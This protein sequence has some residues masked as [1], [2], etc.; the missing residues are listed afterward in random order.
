M[1]VSHGF[2]HWVEKN[3]DDHPDV[4]AQA[5]GSHTHRYVNGRLHQKVNLCLSNPKVDEFIIAEWKEAGT[6]DFWNI[7]NNDLGGRYCLCDDCR[8]MDIPPGQSLEDL[9]AGTCN[10][11]GRHV[12]F[13]RRLL[14]QMREINPDITLGAYAFQQYRFAPPPGTG[15]EGMM[16]SV[17]S[18][19]DEFE[20]WVAWYETGARLYLR[21]NWWHHT[22][23]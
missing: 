2:Q 11:T 14:D 23:R 21:P 12:K 16:I 1:R 6:P 8:A 13:W 15:L 5:R 19:H 17:V 7:G 22:F 9:W 4:F 20:D 3:F 18:A 10:V